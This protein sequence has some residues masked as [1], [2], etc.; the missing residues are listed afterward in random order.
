M[1]RSSLSEGTFEPR[2]WRG[3]PCPGRGPAGLCPILFLGM[4]ERKLSHLLRLVFLRQMPI[5][6]FNHLGGCMTCLRP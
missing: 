3:K 6:L 4:E 5:G 2:L 1:P